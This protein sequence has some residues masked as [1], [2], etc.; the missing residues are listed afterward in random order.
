MA[1]KLPQRTGAPVSGSAVGTK[2]ISNELGR[3]RMEVIVA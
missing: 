2:M 3:T 1:K